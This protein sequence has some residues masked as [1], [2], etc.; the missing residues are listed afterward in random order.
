MLTDINLKSVTISFKAL[1]DRN[2]VRIVAAL[3]ARPACVCELAYALAIK[4]SN[5]SRHL[6][7]LENAGLI[8]GEREGVWINYRIITNPAHESM[9]ELIKTLSSL[10]SV[11]KQDV[12]ALAKA[13]RADLCSLSSD[14]ESRK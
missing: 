14:T 7:V 3:L 10:D 5:L 6:R 1:S 11:L 12:V 13:D 4:Q 2:R 9:F 8:T